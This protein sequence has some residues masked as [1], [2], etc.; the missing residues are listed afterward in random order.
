MKT[1]NK[2]NGYTDKEHYFCQSNCIH[3][4]L[5]E[6][7]CLH[8][9]GLPNWTEKELVNNIMEVLQQYVRAGFTVHTVLMNMM[10]EKFK[11]LLSM[12]NVKRSAAMR[13]VKE[14]CRGIVATLPFFYLP[15]QLI[16][17]LVQYVAMW[18]N[19]LPNSSRISRKW[20]PLE[21]ICCGWLDTVFHF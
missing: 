4:H 2:E 3:H 11:A 21:L 15:Q 18:L 6:R 16:I 5:W 8:K 13:T 7:Y 12:F 10:F 9:S 14:W 20:N 1:Q 17:N 19:E